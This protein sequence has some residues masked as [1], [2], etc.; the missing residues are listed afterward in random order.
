MSVCN[1]CG[2]SFIPYYELSNSRDVV[3]D[4]KHFLICPE[5]SINFK[6][7]EKLKDILLHGEHTEASA[8]G[9]V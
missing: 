4:G 6:D 3:I 9:I 7:A 8:T 1:I 2:I 5:C